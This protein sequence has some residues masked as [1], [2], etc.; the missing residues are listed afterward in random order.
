MRQ[1]TPWLAIALVG[2]VSLI[3]IVPIIGLITTSIRPAGDLVNGW[4]NTDNLHFTL[5]AWHTVW[6]KYKLS[7]AFF[8]SLE[9]T[10]LSTILTMLLAPAA[11]YAFHYLKFKGRRTLLIIVINTFILPQQVVIIP[12]FLLWR[13]LGLIDNIWAVIIPYVG[14]S[15]SWSIFMIKNFFND[16]PPELIEAS[17]LD[18]CGPIQTF[19]YIV[20]PNSI[21]PIA[22]VGIL[23]FLWSWNSLLLPMLYLRHHISLTVLLARISSSFEPNIGQ[24]SVAAIITAIVPLAIFIVFQKYF[25]A[26][27]KVSSG[28]KE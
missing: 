18:G 12:L 20:L 11:A 19:F 3:W 23:Q 4:W 2:L 13:H 7:T 9:L 21:A 24:Q 26:G 1:R 28:G 5:Y 8:V 6:Q 16:F 15:F 22:A 27:S 17:K 10:S 25:A 14:M